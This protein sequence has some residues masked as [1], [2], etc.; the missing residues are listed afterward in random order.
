MTAVGGTLIEACPLA[1]LKMRFFT[2]QV[3]LINAPWWDLYAYAKAD[4]FNTS[5]QA[6]TLRARPIGLEWTAGPIIAV[7]C[8]VA[9]CDQFLH[10]SLS[11]M[12]PACFLAIGGCLQDPMG[13]F[14]RSASSRMRFALDPHEA[15]VKRSLFDKQ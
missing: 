12:P 1:P 15:K 9:T 11:D 3:F 8:Y 13:I 4:C 2:W 14:L 7:A 10:T 5:A 6:H